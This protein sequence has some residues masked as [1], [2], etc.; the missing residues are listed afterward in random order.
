MPFIRFPTAR[1]PATAIALIFA[2]TM[3]APLARAADT[4]VSIDNFT[5]APQR[6]T[7]KTGTTVTWTNRDDIPHTVTSKTAV[8]KS[9]ALDTGDTFTFTFT[10]PGSYPYFCALH[11]HMTGTIVVEADAGK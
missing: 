6:I 11:P 1:F 10:A 2:A 3:A 5:F 8:F 7:V 4:A 9:K